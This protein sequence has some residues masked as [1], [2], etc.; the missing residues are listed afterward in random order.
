MFSLN[1]SC[2]HEALFFLFGG[3]LRDG[4]I[5]RLD[6]LALESGAGSWPHSWEVCGGKVAHDGSKRVCLVRCDSKS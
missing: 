3:K 1:N 5:Q 4:K 2:F 6:C